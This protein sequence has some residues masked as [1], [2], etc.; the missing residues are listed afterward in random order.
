MVN[1]VLC[2]DDDQVTLM[3]LEK[4]L[5]KASFTQ[6]IITASNGQQAIDVLSS[7]RHS[8]IDLVFLDLNMPVKNG[9]DV[10]EEISQSAQKQWPGVFVLTSSVTP[11]DETRSSQYPSVLGYIRK[12]LTTEK[13][14]HLKMHSALRALFS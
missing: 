5:M 7:D 6:A 11:E 14:D 10:L 9:W 8:D 3:L 13:V 12:P 4:T 1:K 2:V